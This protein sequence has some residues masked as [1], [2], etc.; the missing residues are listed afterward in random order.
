MPPSKSESNRVQTT[1]APSADMPERAIARYTAQVVKAT[2]GLASGTVPS[3]ASWRGEAAA[4]A[5]AIAP[6]V[7][8]SA[9]AT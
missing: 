7:R 1:S 2:R 3:G 6:T 8:F 9:A 4:T 5:R